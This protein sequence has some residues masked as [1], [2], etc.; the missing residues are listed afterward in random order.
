M[1]D[2]ETLRYWKNPKETLDKNVLNNYNSMEA[3]GKRTHYEPE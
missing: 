1:V 2:P 3:I